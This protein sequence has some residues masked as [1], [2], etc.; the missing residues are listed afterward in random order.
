MDDRVR[1][2][3]LERNLGKNYSYKEEE[4]S[5][6]DTGSNLGEYVRDILTALEDEDIDN[7][8]DKEVAIIEEIVKVLERG[9]KEKLPAFT[10]I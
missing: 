7:L 4:R 2:E 3:E 8:K 10:D 9:Q 6:D 1:D 5:A